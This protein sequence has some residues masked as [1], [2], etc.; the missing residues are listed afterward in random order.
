MNAYST[1]WADLSVECLQKENPAVLPNLQSST[2]NR[3]RAIQAASHGCGLTDGE[4]K[5]IRDNL[6]RVLAP[7]ATHQP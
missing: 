1:I 4:A 6:I 3:W 5:D 7:A 2:V